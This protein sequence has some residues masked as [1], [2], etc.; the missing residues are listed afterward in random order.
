VGE[1]HY[2]LYY[3]DEYKGTYG[4]EYF[5]MDRMIP[6][7][8]LSAMKPGEEKV[9][10]G[11]G[12]TIKVKC[13]EKPLPGVKPLISPF[14]EN[15]VKEIL[16]DTGNGIMAPMRCPS[17]GLTSFGY[18]IRVDRKFKTGSPARCNIQPEMSD[19]IDPIVHTA[20]VGGGLRP[21]QYL[22][23]YEGDYIDIPPLGFVL[24]VS[25]E[26]VCMPKNAMAVC[27]AKSTLARIGLEASVT[28]IEAGWEGYITLEIFNKNPNMLRLYAGIGIMQLMFH[29]S[30]DNCMVSYADRA[31]KYMDQPREPVAGS[32]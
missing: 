10:P 22:T 25:I 16:I 18:D 8:M 2:E 9:F 12:S 28:P 1:R 5:A 24:G 4:I 7:S 14:I 26:K 13:T 20:A 15:S 6:P 27:M 31:G 32:F 3:D 23:E 19:F 17:Y 21:D 29:T 30:A 11:G